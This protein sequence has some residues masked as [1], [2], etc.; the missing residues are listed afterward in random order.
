MKVHKIEPEQLERFAALINAMDQVM[1]DRP[2]RGFNW[3]DWDEDDPDKM[4]L[5]EL[6]SFVAK[7]DGISE[8]EVD[9]RLFLY[10][11]IKR[12]FLKVRAPQLVHVTVEVLLDNCC[13]PLA[14]TLEFHPSIYFNHVAPE[15]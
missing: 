15:Q 13:D 4:E 8:K 11:W 3:A 6:R 1:D 5:Y 10:E 14:D 7:W 2:M 9:E 12:K